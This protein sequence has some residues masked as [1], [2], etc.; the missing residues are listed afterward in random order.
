MF[1]NYISTVSHI[2]KFY[3]GINIHGKLVLLAYDATVIYFNKDLNSIP[4]PNE[5][6]YDKNIHLVPS[7]S[8]PKLL[9]LEQKMI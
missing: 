3:F 5:G 4:Q 6:G 9:G 1:S 2:N 7:T 8:T